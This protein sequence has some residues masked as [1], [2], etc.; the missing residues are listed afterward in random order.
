M[1]TKTRTKTPRT[2]AAAQRAVRTVHRRVV[3]EVPFL[4][5]ETGKLIAWGA[6]GFVGILAIAGL[7]AALVESGTV[8]LPDRRQ[9]E[10]RLKAI[11]NSKT[12]HEALGWL[13]SHLSDLRDEIQ[14]QLARLS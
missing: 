5:T 4:S 1:A 7:A 2:R 12:P 8:E 3:R 11:Q 6:A 14:T 10:A 9:I 13:T